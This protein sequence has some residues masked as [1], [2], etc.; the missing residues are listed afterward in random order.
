MKSFILIERFILKLLTS[1]CYTNGSVNRLYEIVQVP[2]SLSF[3]WICKKLHYF[4]FFILI[5]P[6][7]LRY[8]SRNCAACNARLVLSPSSYTFSLAQCKTYSCTEQMKSFILIERF[9][10]K[11]LTSS[12]YTNGSVNRLYEIVQVPFSLSFIWIC[13]KLHYFVFFI[14]IWPYKLRYL[15]RNCAAC[16]ARLVLSPSSY[17]FSL[18]Q[19]KTY[20]CKRFV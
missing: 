16:N 14:L 17:T 3:I 1:S 10:L 18:A 5:W 12:C 15:S 13:K 8:L 20:S 2:F 19:C 9:I 11:L 6:Y 7:K 4:V